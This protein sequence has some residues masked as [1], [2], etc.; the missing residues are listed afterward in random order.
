MT[1]TEFNHGDREPADSH[2]GGAEHFK[3]SRR[4]MTANLKCAT[5]RPGLFL[6]IMP[7]ILPGFSALRGRSKP[8]TELTQ[9]TKPSAQFG[10]NLKSDE[11]RCG[12]TRPM[13][14]RH[15][16]RRSVNERCRLV[17]LATTIGQVSIAKALLYILCHKNRR[18]LARLASVAARSRF[19]E[20]EVQLRHHGEQSLLTFVNHRIYGGVVSTYAQ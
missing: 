1:R 9:R 15:F 11:S 12:L 3:L 10:K 6:C 7:E 2:Q 16:V 14:R 5:R 4:W 13:G 8:G 20:A 18:N 17:E 19:P